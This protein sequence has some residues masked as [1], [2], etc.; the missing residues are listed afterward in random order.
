MG[1]QG[2]CICL[3]DNHEW[4]VLKTVHRPCVY[5]NFMTEVNGLVRNRGPGVQ[6]L[7]GVCPRLGV[8]V[9]RYAGKTLEEYVRQRRLTK[10]QLAYVL[11][12]V[13]KT[14]KAMLDRGQC[15][16]DIKM[17][18]VCVKRVNSREPKV[19]L[20]DFGKAGPVGERPYIPIGPWW[21]LLLPWLAPE[22]LCVGTSSHASEV[23]SLGYLAQGLFKEA[24][25]PKELRRWISRS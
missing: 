3:K 13:M 16:N 7:C 15:H 23:Y 19:T 6:N 2:S 11:E 22:L 4:F 14:C 12:A 20:I 24:S 17:N 25:C 21:H 9:S 10:L 8:I 18:N 1:G 5:E